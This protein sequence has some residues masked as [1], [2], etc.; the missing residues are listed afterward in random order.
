MCTTIQQVRGVSV[1]CSK[2]QESSLPSPQSEAEASD[3][4][5]REGSVDSEESDASIPGLQQSTSPRNA[6]GSPEA[7]S[8]EDGDTLIHITARVD[9][10]QIQLLHCSGGF[11]RNVVPENCSKSLIAVLDECIAA[12][13][14]PARDPEYHA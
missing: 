12:W 7:G 1:F 4:A 11:M 10:F 3:I 13:L 5:K 8:P 2:E 6:P 9:L 14:Y